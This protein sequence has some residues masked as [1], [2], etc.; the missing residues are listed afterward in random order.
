MPS[1]Q[2]PP[3]SPS[4]GAPKNSLSPSNFLNFTEES[5]R[6]SRI[7]GC[8]DGKVVRDPG[9]PDLWGCIAGS[10]QTV[11]VSLYERDTSGGVDDIQMEWD[12]WT[13]DVGYGLHPDKELAYE[14]LTKVVGQYAPS[15]I[16]AAK[17][18]FSDTNNVTFGDDKF[19]IA[20]TYR[21]GPSIGTR[22]IDITSK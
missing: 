22:M 18:A 8:T 1:E 13:A 17:S 12:D 14:W 3:F 4:A 20:Y 11:K 2:E 5:D 10:A 19:R 9:E 15:Q 16:D 21:Q 6:L 7:I